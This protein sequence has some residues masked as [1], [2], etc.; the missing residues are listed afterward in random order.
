MDTSSI[1]Q[2][3]PN[4]RVRLIGDPQRIGIATD[5]VQKRRGRLLRQVLFPDR[6]QYVPEDQLE[7]VPDF[8]TA[9]ELL[10][11]AKLGRVSNLRRT[12]THVRLTGQLADVIYSMEATN[13]DF[14]SYQFK[15]VLK[16]LQSPSNGI[17]IADEVGLGKT[18]EAGL[19]WT[20]LR[21][22]YDMRRLLVLCPAVLKTK[23]QMELRFRFG[24]KADICDARQVLATLQDPGASQAGFAMIASLQGLRPNRDWEDP[25]QI[26]SPRAQLARYLVEKENEDQL[27]DLLVIDEAHYMRNPE[28]KTNKLGELFRNI[29][30]H[31][32]FMT[33]TPVHNK[34]DDL[35]SVLT[36]LDPDTFQ[37]RGDFS[38]ILEANRPLVEARDLILRQGQLDLVELGELLE[39]ASAH[40]LLVGN[41]QLVSLA[42][43]AAEADLTDPEIR[44]RF[45][46]RLETVNLLSHVY[47][48]TR[49]RDVEDWRVVR[50]PVAES[51]PLSPIEKEF[52]EMVTSVVIDYAQGRNINEL[53]LLAMPQR[54]MSSCMPAALKTW[55]NRR[56]DLDPYLTEDTNSEPNKNQS[57]SAQT[58]G[59]LTR[60]LVERSDQMVSFDQLFANDS[61]YIRLKEALSRFFKDHPDEKIILFSTFIGTL[62]YLKERLNDDGFSN[63]VMTGQGREPKD[64]I[65][66]R[67]KAPDGPRILLSSEV[68]GEGI[69]LQFSRVVVNYDL[70]WNPMRVEQRI[71]R[72]DRLGQ[73]ADQVLIWN[74]FYDQTIDSRIYTRLYEKLDLCR[75]A[76]GDFEAVLGDELRKLTNDLLA[77]HLSPKQQEDRIDQTAQALAARRQDEERLEENASQLIAYGDY[78]L[79]QVR[80]AKDLHRWIT[81]ADLR[82]Y[83]IDYMKGRYPGCQFK[84]LNTDQP[85]FEISLSQEA[86]HDL[87]AYIQSRRPSVQ[88]RLTQSAPGPI[89]AKFENRVS[90]GS[91]E[92][93]ELISQFHPLVR[94]IG[95]EIEAGEHQVRPAV[96]V[97]LDRANA[98]GLP[99]AG[100]Y[101]IGCSLWSV[102]GLRTIEKLMF[103]A[104]P[105]ARNAEFLSEIASEQ[106]AV[107]AAMDGSDWLEARNKV[108][109]ELAHELAN[110]DLFGELDDRYQVF[111]DEIRAQNA[112]R[113]E[114]QERSLDR[115]LGS[116]LGKLTEI[117]EKHRQAGRDSL[118][119]A[120]QGRIEALKARVDRQ[121]RQINDKSEIRDESQDICVALV[122]LS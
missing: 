45:A 105:L 101:L 24:V 51:I 90:G 114:I 1:G 33:A 104:K 29:S 91:F 93:V 72:I 98:E 3:E 18:I 74:L 79:S 17:L 48:R 21:S 94:F 111:V 19:I 64:D 54:Q 87:A 59:P 2:I 55:Q 62:D 85:D 37:R 106:L 30:E 115:H 70:P 47:T 119:K 43:T 40:P 49:K 103:L 68:G 8:E 112:D 39:Q 67:F 65:I 97:C 81:E 42:K 11:A 20:E 28:T 41:R 95:I 84:Q 102:R 88:T 60:T 50:E 61:K 110:E 14:Y 96:G 36:I 44:S 32:V 12:I 73:T 26:K 71:G 121:R 22:R 116:Q 25:D 53:F 6:P 77:G 66:K 58:M 108:D 86:K 35:F 57:Q 89:K 9:L 113:A 122:E 99:P 34:N 16:L 92:A 100:T 109:F 82:A 80:A 120:T 78:I 5:K 4:A 46:Y 76:L 63:I 56:P 118:V 107:T 52:Y 117:A 31:A 27:V 10:R 23:W 75:N 69:D 83:V 38:D 7:P 15:P 13:T